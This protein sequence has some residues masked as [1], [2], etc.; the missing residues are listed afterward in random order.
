MKHVNVT[1]EMIECD[2]IVSV[3]DVISTKMTS[4][5][6]ANAT[7][8]CHSKKV[9]D[10]YIFHTVLLVIIL[11]LIMTIIY[12]HYGKQKGINALTI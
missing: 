3:T 12:Y 11:L 1:V 9:R 4:A 5:L 7:K 10:C 6:A 2:E 8:N